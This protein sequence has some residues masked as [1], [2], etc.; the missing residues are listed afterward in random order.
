MPKISTAKISKQE[1][2]KMLSLLY[3]KI[4]K[5][6]NKK[7]IADFLSDILMDSE[8]VMI[9]RRLQIAKMLMEEKTYEEVRAKLGVGFDNIKTVRHKI[10]FGSGGYLKFIKEIQ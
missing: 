1:M 9:L 8:K 6:K 3:L 2:N 5:L 10:D 7:E 4:A